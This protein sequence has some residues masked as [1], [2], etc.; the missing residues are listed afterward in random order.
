MPALTFLH[1]PN[2]HDFDLEMLDQVR[3][4][5]V[6]PPELQDAPTA[7]WEDLPEMGD[8][9]AP[10]DFS[11]SGEGSF[12]PSRPNR[13][14]Q[15]PQPFWI[16]SPAFL[17]ISLAAVESVIKAKSVFEPKTL[18]EAM[19]CPDAEEW[20][21]SIATEVNTLM[22]NHTFE[23][24]DATCVPEGRRVIKSKWVFKVK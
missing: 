5:T 21:E 23:V 3:A 24:I 22:A 6:H 2:M 16:A 12:S 1:P 17:S 10:D 13:R 19:E 4:R 15:P 11:D 7:P 9:L 14:R 18:K 8:D 20:R